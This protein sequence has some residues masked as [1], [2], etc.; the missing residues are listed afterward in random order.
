MSSI[1]LEVLHPNGHRER[2]ELDTDEPISIGRGKSATVKLDDGTAQPI[3]AEIRFSNRRATIEDQQTHS[4]THVNDVRVRRTRLHAGDTISIGRSHISVGF[5]GSTYRLELPEAVVAGTILSGTA[6]YESFA[7][8]A[9]ESDMWIK[10]VWRCRSERRVVDERVVSRV[11]IDDDADS[12]E[13]PFQLAVPYSPVSFAGSRIEVE[14]LVILESAPSQAD[15]FQVASQSLTVL[16]GRL[17]P[18]KPDALMA[19]VAYRTAALPRT[20]LAEGVRT[21]AAVIEHLDGRAPQDQMVRD[22]DVWAAGL[23][24][25]ARSV[26]LLSLGGR[27]SFDQFDGPWVTFTGGRANLAW[28]VTGKRRGF[29]RPKEI[30][31]TVECVERF[32]GSRVVHRASGALDRPAGFRYGEPTDIR[33]GVTIPPGLPGSLRTSSVELFWRVRLVIRFGWL[34]RA[35][36]TNEFW[37]VPILPPER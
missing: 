37:V 18:A 23:V 2:V 14:W 9:R 5:S 30:T 1:L 32:D 17:P 19:K 26:A 25:R 8:E 12:N 16:P 4:G 15:W 11:D 6:S 7:G 34:R 10:L 33:F 28:T 36:E 35:T 22:R 27:V 21:R 13:W 3:H 20:Q 29:Q 24:T 31:W